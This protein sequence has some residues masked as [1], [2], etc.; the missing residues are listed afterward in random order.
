MSATLRP[1]LVLAK[2][3]IYMR[4]CGNPCALLVLVLIV[5]SPNLPA[6]SSADPSDARVQQLY[7]E[8]KTAESQG[9]FA[10]AAAKYESL[11]QY[12]PRLAAA[13]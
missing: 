4:R 7:S 10:A 6:Q 12:A 1:N 3:R 11:L 8:A 9:D 13:R 2:S 5:F